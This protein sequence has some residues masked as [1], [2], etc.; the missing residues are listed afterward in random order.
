MSGTVGAGDGAGEPVA[1]RGPRLWGDDAPGAAGGA[2][3]AD[4]EARIPED[5][6]DV[7]IAGDDPGLGEIAP[8]DGIALTQ[9]T[10]GGVGIVQEAGAVEVAIHAGAPSLLE[11]ERLDG[12]RAE[13]RHGGCR[14]HGGMSRDLAAA[15]RSRARADARARMGGRMECGLAGA[16]A[17]D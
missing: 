5:G 1:E 9:G 13:K 16:V 11:E 3:P 8:M 2:G 12:E 6:G 14:V 7:V 17:A 15:V 10:V 4:A